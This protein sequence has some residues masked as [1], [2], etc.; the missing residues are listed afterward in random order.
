VR[1]LMCKRYMYRVNIK[2]IPLIPLSNKSVVRP[3]RN[4]TDSAR[5]ARGTIIIAS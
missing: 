3:E 2:H 4:K 5:S 1:L